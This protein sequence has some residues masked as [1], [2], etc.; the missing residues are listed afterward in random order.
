MKEPTIE[1]I[2]RLKNPV[3]KKNRLECFNYSSAGYYFITICTKNKENLFGRIIGGDEINPPWMKYS[4]IGRIVEKQIQTINRTQYV[5]VDHYVVMP[6]HIH[7]ILIVEKNDHSGEIQA[8]AIIPHTIGGFKR[9][10]AK[11]I[12]TD[13]FQRSYHD[14]IIRDQRHYETIWNYI[15]DNPRRW[16]EDCFYLE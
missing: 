7:M 13:L 10:C 16:K 14:H 9:L 6:N 4:E 2:N 1:E 5:R 15:T 3:R 11:E 12:G 8:N